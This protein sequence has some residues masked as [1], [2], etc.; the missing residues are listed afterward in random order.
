MKKGVGTKGKPNKP[1]HPAG[2]AEPQPKAAGA[3][4]QAAARLRTRRSIQSGRGAHGRVVSSAR[5]PPGPTRSRLRSKPEAARGGHPVESPWTPWCVGGNPW[6]QTTHRPRAPLRSS[7]FRGSPQRPSTKSGRADAA[8]PSPW[9]P[10]APPRQPARRSTAPRSPGAPRPVPPRPPV[11]PPHAWPPRPAHRHP[12][13][14]SAGGGF[15]RSGVA[16]G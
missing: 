7:P 14:N 15:R 6:V 4:A 1:T 10:P 12:L 5:C 8:I 16:P 13:H 2:K 9:R 11:L 3:Q